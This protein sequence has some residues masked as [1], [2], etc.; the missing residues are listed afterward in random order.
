VAVTCPFLCRTCN[1]AVKVCKAVHP[2][3]KILDPSDCE[4]FES[5]G[6]YKLRMKIDERK[7]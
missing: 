3:K 2:R 4:D 7:D 5:C 6:L 1:R